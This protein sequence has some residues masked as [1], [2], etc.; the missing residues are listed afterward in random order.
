MLSAVANAEDTLP[1]SVA[2]RAAIM[3]VAHTDELGLP[4]SELSGRDQRRAR[5]YRMCQ[6]QTIAQMAEK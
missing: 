3:V 1:R 6:G 5:L 4:S 2:H